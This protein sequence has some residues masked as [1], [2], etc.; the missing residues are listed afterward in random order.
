VVNELQNA[1]GK[2]VKLKY[3]Q[4]YKAMAWQGDTDYFIVGVEVIQE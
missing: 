2:R 1:E 4:R 3:K